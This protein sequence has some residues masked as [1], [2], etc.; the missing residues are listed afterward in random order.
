LALTKRKSTDVSDPRDARARRTRER[1]DAAFVELLHR[2]SYDG[3]RVS[4]IAKKSGVGRATFYAHYTGKGDLLRSQMDRVVAP[5]LVAS[6]QQLA[7][8]VDATNLFAHILARPRIY[9]ALMT[10]AGRRIA[11]A[12][13]EARI[14][15]LLEGIAARRAR[16]FAIRVPIVARVL[17]SSLVGLIAWRLEGGGDES[18][19]ALQRA[20]GALCEGAVVS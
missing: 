6:A 14:H 11:E 13:L 10:G 16:P 9:A 5:M 12:S 8:C 19:A 1:I 3:I 20:F 7:P 18:A 15:A 2:R 4:D 17:A